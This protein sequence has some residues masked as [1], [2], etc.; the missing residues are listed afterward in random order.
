MLEAGRILAGG[1]VLLLIT[2]LAAWA[3]PLGRPQL[4]QINGSA[5]NVGN[6]EVAALL[7]F[8]AVGLSAV[9][10]ILAIAGWFAT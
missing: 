7:L 3:N 8:A 1:S 6:P 4:R 5:A 10:A 2:A 9:A